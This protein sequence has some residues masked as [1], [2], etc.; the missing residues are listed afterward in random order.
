MKSSNG[1]VQEGGGR[2]LGWAVGSEHWALGSACADYGPEPRH[3]N[4]SAE[5]GPTRDAASVRL[6]INQRDGMIMPLP[7]PPAGNGTVHQTR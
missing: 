5:L 3:R 7:P 4:L 1:H 6:T 2:R